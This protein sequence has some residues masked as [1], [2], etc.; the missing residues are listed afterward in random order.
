L[1]IVSAEPEILLP[2]FSFKD[3][4]PRL[5][6]KQGILESRGFVDIHAQ[7][8]II[9]KCT[10]GDRLELELRVA[11]A[12][13][14]IHAMRTPLSASAIFALR[15]RLPLSTE[16]SFA[17]LY[18]V[19]DKRFSPIE[20]V[21]SLRASADRRGFY[22]SA[23][24]DAEKLH[25]FLHK[26]KY[27]SATF[28]LLFYDLRGEFL[29]HFVARFTRHCFAE[30]TML[31]ADHILSSVDDDPG[32]LDLQRTQPLLMPFTLEDLFWTNPYFEDVPEHDLV[33]HPF[34]FVG[35]SDHGTRQENVVVSSQES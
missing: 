21:R 17:E 19:A 12:E 2:A 27:E 29:P 10:E 18:Y 14:R 23:V 13:G 30:S 15:K 34:L 6:H 28:D 35:T 25:L 4:L 7:I 33:H 26:E 32:K 22:A 3:I 16:R 31:Q 1:L 9:E 20:I 24:I 8:Q 11:D 5:P